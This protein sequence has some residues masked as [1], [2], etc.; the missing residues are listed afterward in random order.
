MRKRPYTD[1]RAEEILKDLNANP[2]VKRWCFA[3][4]PD[5]D[6]EPDAEENRLARRYT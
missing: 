2:N 1:E 3:A 6:N 4:P 5:T